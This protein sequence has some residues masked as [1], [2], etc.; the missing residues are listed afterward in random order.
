[1]KN[2]CLAARAEQST[3]APSTDG[4]SSG[5]E[6]DLAA[7]LIERGWL[8]PWHV[9]QLK[10]GRTKFNLGPY[11]ILDPIGQGGM[12][13]VFRGEHRLMGRVVAIKVLPQHKS[14][15]EAI[16]SF[17]REIRVQAQLD[18]ENL[19]RAYDAGYEGNVYFL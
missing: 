9:E 3:S 13:H 7:L 2:L 6:R 12:G 4:D 16:D 1:L 10:A 19:V 8:K 17:M 5:G 15:P 11:R 14:S 18:H